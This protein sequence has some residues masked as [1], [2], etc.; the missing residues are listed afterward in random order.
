M[1]SIKSLIRNIGSG[2]PISPILT[3]RHQSTSHA[4]HGPDVAENP[5]NAPA[6]PATNAGEPCGLNTAAVVSA[7][8]PGKCTHRM[9][10]L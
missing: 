2:L 1:K 3:R 4:K 6:N 9:T 8:A 7:G 5:D 10:L